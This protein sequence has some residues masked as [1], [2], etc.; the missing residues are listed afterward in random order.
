MRR[1]LLFFI[2]LPLLITCSR[3]DNQ[4]PVQ[5][6]DYS[7]IEEIRIDTKNGKYYRADSLFSDKVSFVKL[8]TREDNLIGEISKIFF[9]DSLIIVVDVDK[10]K[11][12]FM[13]DMQGRYL[14]KIACSGNGPGEY[15]SMHNVFLIQD[16]KQIAVYD[17]MQRKT[18][19][20]TYSG[21]FISEE[22]QPF[23]AYNCE[24]M[25][26]GKRAYYIAELYHNPIFNNS[27]RDVLVVTDE[28]NKF[29]YSACHEFHSENFYFWNSKDFWKYENDLY[30]YPDYQDTLFIIND[31]AA[32][33]K[34]YINVVHEK[35]PHPSDIPNITN[36]IFFK[37]YLTK[38]PYFDGKF[39]ELKDFTYLELSGLSTPI[40]YSHKTKKT[41]FYNCDFINYLYYFLQTPMS[42]YKDNTVVTP[43]WPYKITD[44]NVKEM[45]Y[46]FLPR[47][48][49]DHPT[50]LCIEIEKSFLDSLY[51]DL[52]EEDNPVL[53]FYELNK[54]L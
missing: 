30:F 13:F 45:F 24:Y 38:Y 50:I 54:N 26:S 52:N 14:S 19:Y 7:Q 29:I 1:F 37:N 21:S 47:L 46:D 6:I 41:Y 9:T 4:Y 53:F 11:S 42:R 10:A 31:T 23:P 35:M 8:E 43:I 3:K 17:V 5:S 20:Y 40:I 44:A 25:E 2:L 12:V 28:N 49:I 15:V 39:I 48:K 18:M 32:I 36:D 33:A 22:R 34:Y 16:K 27:D 51:L